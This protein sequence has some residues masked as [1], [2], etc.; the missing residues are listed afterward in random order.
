MATTV[1]KIYHHSNAY[2]PSSAYRLS[3]VLT[4]NLFIRHFSMFRWHKC[5]RGKA[6]I[7]SVWNWKKA[8]FEYIAT[9]H[10]RETKKWGVKRHY[11]NFA[12]VFRNLKICKVVTICCSDFFV[13]FVHGNGCC[14][15]WQLANVIAFLGSASKRHFC[16]R[17]I[18]LFFLEY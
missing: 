5:A 18:I 12:S 4:D 13:E 6:E 14:N 3:S 16:S 10:F 17:K 15:G 1:C 8:M 11:T 2:P 7:Y 9:F